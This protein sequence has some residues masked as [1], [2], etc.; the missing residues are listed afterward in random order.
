[1]SQKTFYSKIFNYLV[2]G[3]NCLKVTIK[4]RE[5]HFRT[6]SKE[7]YANCLQ[8]HQDSLYHQETFLMAMCL[9]K[10]GGFNVANEDKYTL[11]KYWYSLPK[12]QKRLSPYFW[13]AIKEEMESHKYFEAFCYTSGSRTLWYKW[14]CSREIGLDVVQ[15]GELDDFLFNWVLF[16]REEDK[17]LELDE[18]WQRTF[19]EASSMNPKGVEKVQKEWKSRKETERLHRQSII[20][21]AERGETLSEEETEKQ[22]IENMQREY[23]QWVDGEEDDHDK[24]VREYKERLTT[25]LKNG[26]G[27]VSRARE[28]NEL[29]VGAINSL[30]MKSPI[31][32]YTDK[33][34]ENLLKDRPSTTITINEGDEYNQHIAGRYILAKEMKEEEAPSLMEHISQRGK[35]KL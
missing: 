3:G 16:N 31:Q 13:K 25:Y 11:L 4:G 8:Y 1:M 14:V 33:E 17:K 21:A 24:R 19:F 18:K 23:R 7:D 35:P 6:P 10:V 5:Y 32:A 30:S 28:Q 27:V 15:R 2:S 22:Q 12:I 26:A 9:H 20:E 29:D 34:I